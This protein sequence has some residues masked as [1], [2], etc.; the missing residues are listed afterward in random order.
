MRWVLR[1]AL[2]RVARLRRVTLGR[3]ARLLGIS[4]GRVPG[5]GCRLTSGVA[6]WH[7]RLAARIAR[8]DLEARLRIGLLRGIPWL[9]IGLLRG[10]AWLRVG[11]LSLLG[12]SRLHLHG[13][14]RAHRRSHLLRHIRSSASNRLVLHGWHLTGRSVVHSRFNGG[15]GDSGPSLGSVL[16]CDQNLADVLAVELE[17]EPIADTVV[18]AE[19]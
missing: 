5:L 9:R 7:L 2:R 13:I 17:S 14:G 10:I 16:R 3:V 12:H 1:I 11:R 8:S 4:L 6:W 19:R 15:G 18:D